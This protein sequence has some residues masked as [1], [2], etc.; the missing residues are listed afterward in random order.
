MLQINNYIKIA[1]IF[2]PNSTGFM[3]VKKKRTRGMIR[4]Q[5]ALTPTDTRT[6]LPT[7]GYNAHSY[8]NKFICNCL[9]KCLL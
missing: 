2:N 8:I 3:V 4:K 5:F 6:D 9:C 7:N 1:T